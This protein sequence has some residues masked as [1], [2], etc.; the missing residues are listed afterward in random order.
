MEYKALP[1]LL[2]QSIR[3]DEVSRFLDANQFK[4]PK[5]EAISLKKAERDYWLE[6]KKLGI[7]LL[8]SIALNNPAFPSLPEGR[9]NM[10]L[11]RLVQVQLHAPWAEYPKGLKLGMDYGQVEALL[12]SPTQKSSD[13]S[14]ALFRDGHESYYQWYLPLDAFPHCSLQVQLWHDGTLDDVRLGVNALTPIFYLR[15]AL[16]TGGA[17]DPLESVQANFF[18]HWA[19]G[20]GLCDLSGRDENTCREQQLASATVYLEAFKPAARQFV[21]IYTKNLSGHDIHYSGDI[22]RL[23]LSEHSHR[24][25]PMGAEAVAV[26]AHIEPSAA[27]MAKVV[28]LL[29]QRFAEYGEHRLSRSKRA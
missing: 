16:E 18:L 2:G 7:N 5:Q 12:G 10:F 3:S 15:D 27:N 11:P 1:L 19:I 22:A 24:N 14:P 25:N 9:K 26:L 13:V 17:V 4:R 21:R 28:S 8:F 29:D 6:N 20:R 23:F